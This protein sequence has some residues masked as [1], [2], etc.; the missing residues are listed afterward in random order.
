M[1]TTS[2][3][4]GYKGA[5]PKAVAEFAQEMRKLF[6][7]TIPSTGFQGGIKLGV[8]DIVEKITSV[9]ATNLTDQQKAVKALLES[10]VKPSKIK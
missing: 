4:L 3:G 9:G 2:R 5:S 8:G 10:Y 6:P 1:D 7:D